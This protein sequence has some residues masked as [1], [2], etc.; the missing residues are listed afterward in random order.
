MTFR[1]R[2]AAQK[3]ETEAKRHGFDA[4]PI[5]PF[6]IA[7]SNDIEI[8][9]KPSEVAGVSGA[10][11]F[12]GESVTIIHATNIRSAGFQ[13]FTVAHELGHYFLDGHAEEIRASGGHH[14]S[15]AGFTQGD[16]S[17][18]IEADH[19]ASGV[20]MPKR[21]V[22]EV[23]NDSTVGLESILELADRADCSATASAIRAAEC[24]EHPLCIV[25]SEGNAVCYSF[26]SEAFKA[27]K[28]G[29][30]LRKGALLPSGLTLRFND[31][32]ERVEGGDQD[33]DQTDMADWFGGRSSPLDEEVIGLGNYGRTLTVLSSDELVSQGD[34]DAEDE[35]ELLERSWEAKFAYGR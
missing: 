19:F 17:I 16:R 10:I 25:V 5:D 30:F 28:P 4:L 3:G 2:M 7:A 15:K 13:R 29:G 11:I 1:L 9:P 33:C 35:D 23:L 18:E 12:V 20:L 34:E 21:L 26:M 14:F 27:L 22:R 6:A 24:A 32:T 8:V 31:D